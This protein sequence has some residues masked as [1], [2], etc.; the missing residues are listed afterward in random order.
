MGITQSALS[1]HYSECVGWDGLSTEEAICAALWLPEIKKPIRPSRSRVDC[2]PITKTSARSSIPLRP[3]LVDL[4][5][6]DRWA[7]DPSPTLR[8]RATPVG[9]SRRFMWLSKA[10]NSAACGLDYLIDSPRF[11]RVFAWVQILLGWL[12]ATLFVAAITGIVR[13]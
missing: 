1:G 5:Q 3:A 2:R 4:G 11:L 6:V 12:F 8:E 10:W 13:R 9:V 7:P